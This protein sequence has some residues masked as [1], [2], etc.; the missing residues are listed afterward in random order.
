MDPIRTLPLI[1]IVGAIIGILSCYL[2][3][4]GDT[5]GTELFLAY[6]EGFQ[7]FIPFCIMGVSALSAVLS[8]IMMIGEGNWPSAFV[9]FFAGVGLMILTSV[10]SMWTIGTV[11]ASSM[12]SIGFWISYLAGA[13]MILGGSLYHVH[14]T[15]RCR[16]S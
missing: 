1:S 14:M 6:D 4:I 16:A 8:V 12:A 7:R 11:R 15:R 5:A 9:L 2:P 3:W 13:L 10:F